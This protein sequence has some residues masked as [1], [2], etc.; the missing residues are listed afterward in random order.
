M[1]DAHK[2]SDSFGRLAVGGEGGGGTDKGGY[3]AHLNVDVTARHD[4]HEDPGN[5]VGAGQRDGKVGEG[6]LETRL[7]TRAQR[8]NTKTSPTGRG[9]SGNVPH[10]V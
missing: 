5:L 10:F 7:V 9:T 6:G 2:E 8:T 4:G 1:A 3:C